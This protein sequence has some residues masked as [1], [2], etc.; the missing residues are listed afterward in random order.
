MA[1]IEFTD[2]RKIDR[3][4]FADGGVWAAAGFDTDDTVLRQG[5]HAIEDQR[6]FLSVEVVGD[7]ANRPAVAHGAAEFRRQGRLAGT[8]QTANPDAERATGKDQDRKSL[9][10][11]VSWRIEAMS[12]AIVA[13]PRPSSEDCSARRPESR[14][15][16]SSR[17]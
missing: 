14:M 1:N 17:A 11:R 7:D 8:D 9:G 2:G 6:V 4:V 5:L 3:G 16:G 10:L 13:L 12:A 15:V